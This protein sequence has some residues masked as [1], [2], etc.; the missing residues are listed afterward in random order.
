VFIIG[1][2]THGHIVI[3]TI[4]PVGVNRPALSFGLGGIQALMMMSMSSIWQRNLR[5]LHANAF[6]ASGVIFVYSTVLRPYRGCYGINPLVHI[7]GA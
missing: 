1:T 3:F 2:S 7:V 5:D 6:A 4:R